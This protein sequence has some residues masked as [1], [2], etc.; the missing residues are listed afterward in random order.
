[1]AAQQVHQRVVERRG[2]DLLLMQDDPAKLLARRI[3]PVK[4]S[5]TARRRG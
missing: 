3:T 5:I 4:K 1:M 2:V